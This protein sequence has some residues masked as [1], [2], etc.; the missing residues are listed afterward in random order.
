LIVE[1]QSKIPRSKR[2]NNIRVGIQEIG[3]EDVYRIKVIRNTVEQW[4]LQNM[5]PDI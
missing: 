3:Y 4:A 2:E 1:T 5:V